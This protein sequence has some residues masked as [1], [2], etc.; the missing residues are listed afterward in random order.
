MQQ[1]YIFVHKDKTF[2]ND[3]KIIGI[4]RYGAV[5]INDNDWQL[6]EEREIEFFADNKKI[7][8]KC[9]AT[10]VKNNVAVINF[11]NMPASV[12]NRIT[13]YYMQTAAK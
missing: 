11:M 1:N 10:K 2:T 4:N 7:K 9:V 12:I 6:G 5:I 8:V 13:Y 3:V